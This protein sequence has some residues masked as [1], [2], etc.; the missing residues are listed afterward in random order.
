MIHLRLSVAE[1]TYILTYC[2]HSTRICQS[3]CRQTFDA[4]ISTARLSQSMSELRGNPS[5][6]F[7]LGMSISS[8]SEKYY[9]SPL[10]T[11]SL[12]LQIDRTCPDAVALISG[13]GLPWSVFSGSSERSSGNAGRTWA[14]CINCICRAVSHRYYLLAQA[15]F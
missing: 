6:S 12:A 2:S 5:L 13:T 11:K 15:L 8:I 4:P 7:R 14:K 3:H 10:C 1:L 9:E